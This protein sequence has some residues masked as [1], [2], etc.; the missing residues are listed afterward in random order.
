MPA[1]KIGKNSDKERVSLLH[2]KNTT[3]TQSNLENLIDYKLLYVFKDENHY[4]EKFY[5]D[6]MSQK[7]IPQDMES[8]YSHIGDSVNKMFKNPEFLGNIKDAEVIVLD[9]VSTILKNDFTVT[10]FV[11]ILE[12]DYYTHTHSLNVSIYALCLGKHMGY[13]KK[14][15]EDLGTA[16]LLHD[17]G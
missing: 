5:D 13:I 9:M 16:A 15:L 6:F 7:V 1:N 14:D 4:Y 3:V 12:H 17:L 10:S 2:E 11:S 8:F